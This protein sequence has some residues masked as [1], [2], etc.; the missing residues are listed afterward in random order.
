MRQNTLNVVIAALGGEGGGVLADWIAATAKSEGWQVQSTSV[1]GVAQR[2]GATI[3]YIEMFPQSE[4]TPV[5]SLFPTQGDV[6]LVIASEI[7]E[8]GRMVQR[9]LVTPD[10]T[11]LLA[12]DHRVYGI[13]EKIQLADGIVDG[14]IL[15]QICAG[16][17]KRFI[18]FDLLELARAHNT[19]ISAT[20]FGAIAGA[21]LLPFEE[22]SYEAVIR[23]SGIQVEKNLTAFRAA[24]D[25]A[26]SIASDS[27]AGNA[28]YTPQEQSPSK[29]LQSDE[30]CGFVLPEGTTARGR[31][32]LRRLACFPISVQ[33]IL[34]TAVERLVDY[35][36]ADY[37]LDYIACMERFRASA[38]GSPDRVSEELLRELG[39]YLALWLS[40]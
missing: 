5:M 34:L 7:V 12:S 23:G 21:K 10:R 27:P 9:G 40:F 29:A 8:A 3:Y 16:Q 14:D 28:S 22:E 33:P 26:A 17:A 4:N 18:H 30:N 31:E 1:P 13:G 24:R 39:R 19:V 32:V 15:R 36:N 6:D 25:R 37:A 11:E 20:L 2:T 35:Q 38:E